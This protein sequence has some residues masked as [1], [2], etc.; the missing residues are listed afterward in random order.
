MN[1]LI[2]LRRV[3]HRFRFIRLPKIFYKIMA[4][5]NNSKF[6]ELCIFYDIYSCL[7]HFVFIFDSDLEKIAFHAS[8]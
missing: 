4:A 2:Y 1:P 6:K 8:S 5:N 7:S 3:I